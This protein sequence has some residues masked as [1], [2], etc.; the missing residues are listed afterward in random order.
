M[1]REGFQETPLFKNFSAWTWHKA[2]TNISLGRIYTED[3]SFIEKSIYSN[4]A[5]KY[6]LTEQS[7]KYSLIE[8]LT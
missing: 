3:M 5:V 1:Y 7:H 4:T 8:T 2:I 6:T